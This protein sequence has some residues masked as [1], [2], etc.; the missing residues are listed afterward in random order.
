MLLYLDGIDDSG[1]LPAAIPTEL[2]VPGIADIVLYPQIGAGGAGGA[3]WFP[4]DLAEIR[5]YDR[6]LRPDEIYALSRFE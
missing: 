5:V 4:G 1:M 3:A 6:A 2:N